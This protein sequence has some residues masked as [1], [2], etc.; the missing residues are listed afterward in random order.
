[1]SFLDNFTETENS[2]NRFKCLHIDDIDEIIIGGTC[3]H[4]FTVPFIYSDYVQSAEI[5]YKEGLTLIL[6]KTDSNFTIEED[7]EKGISTITLVLTPED[8]LLFKRS[9]L[10]TNVQMKILNKD[11]Q[12]LYNV[13]NRIVVR[14]PLDLV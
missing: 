6:T 4:I 13:P 8:T 5:F 10:N 3:T 11:G 2:D 12:V 7:A 9:Y 1:M 14:A